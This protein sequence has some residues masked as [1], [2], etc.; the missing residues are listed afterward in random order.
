GPDWQPNLA[1][2]MCGYKLQLEILRQLFCGYRD[3]YYELSTTP[4]P[5]STDGFVQ[6]LQAQCFSILANLDI[7]MH[8]GTPGQLNYIEGI[9]PMAAIHLVLSFLLGIGDGQPYDIL[10][11]L[12]TLGIV[13][14]DFGICFGQGKLTKT[15]ELVPF[16]LTNNF[17]LLLQD[18]NVRSKVRWKKQNNL[19]IFEGIFKVA[20]EAICN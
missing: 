4:T 20:L 5:P 11:S 15:L 14:I 1:E 2:S 13:H 17:E 19:V 3:L 8:V 9:C 18:L 12:N 10:V 16:R 6:R 7:S